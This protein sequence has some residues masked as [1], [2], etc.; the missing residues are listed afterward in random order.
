[1]ASLSLSTL[2]EL[3]L[4]LDGSIVLHGRR[5][6][7]I[8][9][10]FLARRSPRAVRREELA[11]LL[12]GERDDARARQSLR[13]ALVQLRRAVG[14][15]LEIGPEVRLSD[16]G[17]ELDAARFERLVGEDRFAEAVAEWRG[18][19][20]P[21]AEDVGGESFR[22]WLEAEREGL[23]QRFVWALER[24]VA[25]AAEL[26]DWPCASVWAE[27]WAAT[28]PYE[29][30]AHL[31]WIEALRLAGRVDDARAHHAAFIKRLR[32]DLDAAPSVKFE[33][34]GRA[35][36]TAGQMPGR[37]GHDRVTLDA[38]A[39][40]GRSDA[41]TQMVAAWRTTA[42]G[43]PTC[44][45]VEGVEGIG[46]TRLCSEFQ[47]WLSSTAPHA[48]VLQARGENG[49]DGG[50]ARELLAGLRSAPG[51]SAAP[52]TSLAEL[53]GLVPTLRD[54]FPRLPA[55]DTSAAGVVDALAVVLR[56]V[57]EEAPVLVLVD[58]FAAADA[59]TR[60][61]L[62][63]LL[64]RPLTAVMFVLT[65]RRVDVN[66]FAPVR[67]ASGF[68]L[69]RI[70]LEPL[71]EAEV[72]SLLT[73]AIQSSP[74]ERRQLAAQL[75]AWSA[76]IP[77]DLLA[78]VTTLVENRCLTPDSQRGW[79][80]VDDWSEK[81]IRLSPELGKSIRERV[82]QITPAAR[83]VLDS[84]AVLNAAADFAL[85]EDITGASPD[86]LTLALEE[87]VAG[88]IVQDTG[89]AYVSA[90]EMV[91]RYTYDHVASARRRGLHRASY[92]ALR[93]R[94]VLDDAARNVLA[95]H[96]RHLVD[97]RRR[98]AKRLAIASAAVLVVAV[99]ALVAGRRAAD[100]SPATIA[101]LPFE[102]GGG[103]EYRYLSEGMVDLL[104]T[105]LQGAGGLQVVDPH[106]LLSF[107]N[108][109]QRLAPQDGRAVA[110][111]FGAG[112]FVLGSIVAAAGRLE[113][114][115]S[116][117]D[118]EG[119]IKTLAGAIAEG[120]EKVFEVVDELARQ[121]LTQRE[122][123]PGAQ[124]TRLAGVTTSS[125][126]SLKAY[127]EGEAALRSGQHRTGVE[128]FQRAIEHDSTFALAYH[129][130]AIA[131]S[132]ITDQALARAAA[133]RALLYGARLPGSTRNLL[134]AS[135]A[136]RQGDTKRA[137][138]L[139]LE[140]TATDPNNVAAWFELGDLRYHYN[141]LQG[142]SKGEARG[143][144]ERVLSLDPR[145]G[146]SLVHLFE[147]AAWENRPAEVESKID[148][149]DPGSDFLK[150]WP[151][152]SS[153][154][155]DD[156][157]RQHELI[158]QLRGEPDRAVVRVVIHSAAAYAHNPAASTQLVRLLTA[159]TREPGWRAYGYYLLAQLALAQGQWYEA[160]RQLELLESL[161]SVTAVEYRALW[162]TIPFL[163]VPKAELDELAA[164]LL[165]WKP[166]QLPPS[167]SMIFSAHD[168][169]HTHLRLYLLGLLSVRRG[170]LE[171]ALRYA[172]ELAKLEAPG[173]A[174]FLTAR[175]SRSVRAQVAAIRFGPAEAIRE[176]GDL[177]LEQQSH[178]ANRSAIYAQVYERFARAELL[179]HAGRS[180]EA[181]DEY[182][183]TADYSLSGLIYLQPSLF[184]RGQLYDKLGDE[185]Q[186]VE[187]FARFTGHWSA[188]DLQLQP[189]VSAARARVLQLRSPVARD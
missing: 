166:A 142:R 152:L 118:A 42:A 159:R 34:L 108:T 91:R 147:L 185:Q 106:A 54:R 25:Q 49:L 130:L 69:T 94:P 53:S 58:D 50:T 127:L 165:S 79:R 154:L 111:R 89:G 161:D 11:A 148:A 105:K 107:V 35:L 84:I 7:L 110:R 2:G 9:L 119:K 51:L 47:R 131:A 138:R 144:F 48:V 150:K 126:P 116:L 95:Q 136:W 62:R 112:L 164:R 39:M 98:P 41:F 187:H 21:G 20:L 93:A 8:L 155:Q 174:E 102:V 171:E 141:P 36:A 16:A 149:L 40:V 64:R 168:E 182:A 63:S 61:L 82:E 31:R 134:E 73:S 65:G 153:L 33:Q 122:I 124:L 100:P 184:R 158:S 37:P 80:L 132:W 156:S 3:R 28:L 18:D 5:K 44:I 114:N 178:L 27:Q 45:V 151:L 38:A 90:H 88:H 189:W 43:E 175:L 103:A 167:S 14:A 181:L 75:H 188:A 160:T 10:V 135:L 120:E 172:S 26:G 129:R 68:S 1:M 30:E 128:A 177:R 86:A 59:Y 23:R 72:E 22:A 183:A 123:G 12:W 162:S 121:L 81:R 55:A 140:I 113:V 169:I 66:G 125:F 117:Y 76:G 92:K 104:S 4:T 170:R 179:A 71:E 46:K 186:A 67:T 176:F 6:E 146:E 157:I 99:G 173:D 115:A 74:A 109:K 77:A 180:D 56:E 133:D 145:H 52:D 139:L 96:S 15:V 17:V 143:P 87:L 13:Q 83:Q 70:R 24:L 137:E 19:F 29:E 101:I 97:P 78:L 32:A 57:S 85:L 60:E 163:R